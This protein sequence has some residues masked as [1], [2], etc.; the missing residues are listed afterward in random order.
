MEHFVDF[1]LKCGNWN[2]LNEYTN[3]SDYKKSRS[4]FDL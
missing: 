2:C 4:F 1:G 3:I